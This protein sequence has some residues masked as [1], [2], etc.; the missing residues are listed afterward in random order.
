MGPLQLRLKLS[1]LSERENHMAVFQLPQKPPATKGVKIERDRQPYTAQPGSGKNHI[2]NLNPPSSTR[3]AR[4]N[5]TS[6]RSSA[7]EQP[8]QAD[9]RHVRTNSTTSQNRY[10]PRAGTR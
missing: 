1:P 4:A 7:R 9:L 10:P 2:D 8:E 3:P 5:S 6:S